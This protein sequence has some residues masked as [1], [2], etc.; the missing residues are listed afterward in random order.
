MNVVYAV[1]G[2]VTV[3]VIV[4][5]PHSDAAHALGEDNA[6]YG[7][8][9]CSPDDLFVEGIGRRIALGRAM[10]FMGDLIATE[11]EKSS[12]TKIEALAAK[13]EELGTTV[14]AEFSPDAFVAAAKFL[15]SRGFPVQVDL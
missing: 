7:V 13:A 5:A 15:K 9:V 6:V 2:Q 10:S 3:A 8:A 4:P 11:A 14:S 1:Q 12:V